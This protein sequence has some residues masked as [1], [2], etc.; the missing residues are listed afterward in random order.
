MRNLSRVI[1][2]WFF[3]LFA[4]SAQAGNSPLLI[5]ELQIAGERASDDFIKIYNPTDSDIYLGNYQGSYLRLVKRAKASTKD[6]L[7][8]SWSREP[9]AKIPARG[10]YLWASS[11]DENYPSLVKANAFTKKVLAE[12][13]GIALRLGSLDTGEIIDA[14]GWGDFNNVL[15]EGSP[16][17]ENPAANQQLKRKLINGTYQDTNNNS[18]DFYLYPPSES[19]QTKTEIQPEFQ[20]EPKSEPE[21]SLQ[22]KEKSTIYPSGLVINEI[23]PSPEGPDETGEWIEIFNQNGFEVDLSDWKIEDTVGKTATYIFPKGTKIGPFG[24][25]VLSR[26]TSKITLNNDADGLNLFQPDGK[27]IDSVSYEKAP[28]G[29]S[30][31]R[32]NSKWSWSA[33]LT[34]NSENV[35]KVPVLKTEK[36]KEPAPEKEVKKETKKQLAAIGEQIPKKSQRLFILFVGLTIATFSGII[37][38]ILKKKLK[39][40]Y[41]K[42]I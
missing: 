28:H 20:P 26:P 10:Y 36:I 16:F 29:Q 17:G 25:F 2:V 30:Y 3:L 31:N 7:I 38:L 22:P 18:Q 24:F 5:V 21:P 13:N 27:I 14:V 23:L 8:K 32:T 41:N 1:A 40:S 15:F 34:P 42:N 4:F 12:D 33:I 19:I 39:M 11:K 37:I 6:I 35:V 9:E